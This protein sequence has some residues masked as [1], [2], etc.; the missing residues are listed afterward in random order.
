MDKIRT[1]WIIIILILFFA[2]F[3][4]SHLFSICRKESF[5]TQLSGDTYIDGKFTF[6][7][8]PE[9]RHSKT[10]I[11]L[12]TGWISS[13]SNCT[14]LCKNQ[15]E[16]LDTKNIKCTSTYQADNKNCYCQFSRVE[17]FDTFN[18]LLNL[19]KEMQPSWESSYFKGKWNP[20]KR[21]SFGTWKDLKI[22]Q[23]NSMSISFWIYMNESVM[24]KNPD[25]KR[26]TLFQVTSPDYTPGIN[27]QGNA[28]DRY[29][30]IQILDRTARLHIRGITSSSTN[31]GDND[32]ASTAVPIPGKNYIGFNVPDNPTFVVIT[33]I[34]NKYTFYKDGVETNSYTSPN[35]YKEPEPDAK[36][37]SGYSLNVSLEPQG[38]SMKDLKVYNGAIKADTIKL[39]YKALKTDEK[40]VGWQTNL[41]EGFAG[42]QGFAGYGRQG[43][44]TVEGF[45]NDEVVG[46][47]SD[48][49]GEAVSGF[50]GPNIAST[51]ISD[52][53]NNAFL[54]PPNIV[55]IAKR[56]IPDM[57]FDTLK[58]LS[59][60]EKQICAFDYNK[61]EL[62]N[63]QD[64]PRKGN[65][66]Y[67]WVKYSNPKDESP[68]YMIPPFNS[69]NVNAEI[70]KYLAN[71]DLAP[72][73]GKQMDGTLTFYSEHPLWGNS[74]TRY[75][76]RSHPDSN[77]QHLRSGLK[78]LAKELRTFNTDNDIGGVRCNSNAPV[79]SNFIHNNGWGVCSVKSKAKDRF[80]KMKILVEDEKK[81]AVEEK[82]E[83]IL[84][85]PTKEE[86]LEMPTQ[87]NPGSV[88][89]FTICFWVKILKYPQH[90]PT[91]R[92]FG[93]CNKKGYN[94]YETIS[95]F[96]MNRH[97]YFQIK[98]I[99]YKSPITDVADFNWHHIAWTVDK[100]GSW[101]IYHNG[102]GY[103]SNPVKGVYPSSNPR[104]KQLI[105]GPINPNDA[106]L[107][108]YMGDI[109]FY[110]GV[111]TKNEVW[112]V[113]NNPR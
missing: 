23:R 8:A 99:F 3:I 71:P 102:R 101:G 12:E 5:S 109:R 85:D 107:D 36:V 74:I 63:G 73:I 75:I 66:E 58:L 91:M 47:D 90:N 39:L 2:V 105:G 24:L 60:P 67:N 48:V 49:G 53:G 111:L 6:S 87:F 79:C 37:F 46:K 43:F 112:T 82:I 77:R 80:V 59:S 62:A 41:T 110:D 21:Q 50:E 54:E 92:I 16:C 70:G 15:N 65:L 95:I 108:G 69:S 61:R 19:P 18:D 33:Y 98:D 26:I 88:N 100:D 94:N 22:D 97:L 7:D 30:M 4:L 10:K 78:E 96:I 34:N 81:H 51:Y 86:Q 113:R 55:A 13:E 89:G 11:P 9:R 29:I 84:L 35:A 42:R 76:S 31:E 106:S 1:N 40:G 52:N 83:A 72:E 17:G 93:F 20:V 38:I 57:G 45:D 14:S 104:N 68:K 28:T 44:K 103:A 32:E 25:L 64:N 56:E 27:S